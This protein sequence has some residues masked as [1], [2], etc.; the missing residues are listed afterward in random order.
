MEATKTLKDCKERPALASQS[1]WERV[2]SFAKLND[3]ILLRSKRSQLVV[4]NMPDIWGTEESEVK[5]FMTYCDTMT[6]GLD[7]VL[8][9]H[10]SGHEVF[11]IG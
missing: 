8:F 11:E 10:S 1:E 6:H 5:H 4:M 7:R 3:M 2:A 9:V